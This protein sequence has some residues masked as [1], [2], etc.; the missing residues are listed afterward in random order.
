MFTPLRRLGALAAASLVICL[1]AGC[2]PTAAPTPT[3]TVTG[4]A[5]EEEAFAAAEETYRAYVD[6]LNE[7]DLADPRT[8]ELATSW[9][10]GPLNGAD[11][12]AF[13]E[14]HANGVVLVGKFAVAR[15]TPENWDRDTGGV[16]LDAC[17]DISDTDFLDA[18]GVSTVPTDRPTVLSLRISL[19]AHQTPTGLALSDTSPL[20]G[21]TAC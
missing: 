3:P 18:E 6:A 19:V 13:S 5:T 16:E 2:T 1:A 20:E 11:R 17:L 21:G 7:V 8:F 12:K 4:F 14:Y 10:T 9:S 15:L